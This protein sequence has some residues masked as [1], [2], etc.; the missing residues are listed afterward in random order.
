M[1]QD[2]CAQTSRADTIASVPK[3]IQVTRTALDV[4]MSTNV[5]GDLAAK[6]HCAITTRAVSDVPV[7]QDS[8]VIRSTHAKVC[9]ENM[10]LASRF[11]IIQRN[12]ISDSLTTINILSYLSTSQIK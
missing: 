9:D 10:R 5:L 11:C 3:G 6:T 8:S 4:T 12:L 7:H 2:P 1:A